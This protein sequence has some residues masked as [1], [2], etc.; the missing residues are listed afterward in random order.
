V[1]KT[2]LARRKETLT[3]EIIATGQEIVEGRVADTNTHLAARELLKSGFSV[4]LHTCVGDNRT[5]LVCAIRGALQRSDVIIISG[6]LGPTE[7]DLTREVCALALGVKLLHFKSATSHIRKI[8]ARYNRAPNPAELRQAYFPACSTKIIPNII[9][10]ARGFICEKNGK[11][12]AALSGVPSEFGEMMQRTVLPFLK[13]R[14]PHLQP[15]LCNIFNTIGKSESEVQALALPVLSR[16]KLSWGITAHQLIISLSVWAPA[17]KKAQFDAACEKLRGKLKRFCFSE[18]E[19]TLQE[20]LIQTLRNKH[21]TVAVAESCTGGLILDKLTNVPGASKVLIEGVV[22]YGD[23]SKIRRLGVRQEILARF[24]AVS[25][26]VAAE[27][28]TGIKNSAGTDLAVATTGI[29]GPTG[30][31]AKKP[32]GLV[33]ISVATQKAVRVKRFL[34]TGVRRDIKERA[35][36]AALAILLQAAAKLKT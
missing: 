11:F 31:T 14:F 20:T 28:A 15:Q 22:V 6:G 26:R 3:A 23:D 18:G 17:E 19:V 29:A 8:L 35:A 5:D 21:L 25:E 2:D 9:G 7:D 32:V 24:G 36:N 30:A 4:K 27:M 1:S 34:F 16:Y 12:L 13:K 33:Y 10:T